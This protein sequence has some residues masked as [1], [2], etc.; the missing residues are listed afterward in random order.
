MVKSK[1]V[2]DLSPIFIYLL[3]GHKEAELFGQ[4]PTAKA[5]ERKHSRHE[6]D[7]LYTSHAQYDGNFF[8]I[9]Q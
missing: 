3:S 9:L 4:I 6:H 2:H 5:L 8:M 1:L 7:V